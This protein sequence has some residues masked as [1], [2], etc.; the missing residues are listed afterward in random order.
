MKTLNGAV[1]EPEPARGGLVSSGPII[2]GGNTGC[3]FPP[4]SAWPVGVNI[5]L[6]IEV[7]NPQLYSLIQDEI[8][9]RGAG[10][11][12]SAGAMLA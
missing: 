9:R 4:H 6:N 5:T 10:P 7:P 3:A 2:S 12:P 8:R 1:D 11:G